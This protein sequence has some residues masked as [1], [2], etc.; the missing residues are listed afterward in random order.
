MP[1]G[2]LHQCRFVDAQRPRCFLASEESIVV[3]SIVRGLPE[4]FRCSH[5]RDVP[6]AA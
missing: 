2:Q 6:A 3:T 4:R 1:Q 5:R